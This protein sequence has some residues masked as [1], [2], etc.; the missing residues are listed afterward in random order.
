LSQATAHSVPELHKWLI[1]EQ[2]SDVIQAALKS[3]KRD[4]IIVSILLL[5]G[6]LDSELVSL[7]VED[8][9]ER[10]GRLWILVK[11]HKGIRRRLVPLHKEFERHF[12]DYLQKEC[13]SAHWLFSGQD[14]EQLTTRDVQRIVAVIGNKAGVLELSPGILRNTFCHDLAGAGVRPEVVAALIGVKV[15]PHASI[16]NT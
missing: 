6:L 5:T 7:R 2:R 11:S 3:K 10:D 13:I 8:V 16:K 12:R 4:S 14:G 15:K 1:K 9:Q